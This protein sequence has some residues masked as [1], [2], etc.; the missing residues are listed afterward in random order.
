MKWHHGRGFYGNKNFR[1]FREGRKWWLSDIRSGR[2]NAPS[3]WF[4]TAKE[5]L[6]MAETIEEVLTRSIEVMGKPRPKIEIVDKPKNKIDSGEMVRALGASPK[7]IP[8]PSGF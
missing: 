4:W 5:A 3:W 2:K 1:I 6:E 7:P 8:R